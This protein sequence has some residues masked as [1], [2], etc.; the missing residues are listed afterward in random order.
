[1]R[2]FVF[3][4]LLLTPLLSWA[5]DRGELAK[6]NPVAVVALTYGETE[7]K[8]VDGDWRPLYW[9]DLIRPED[10]IRCAD[11]G[12][13]VLTFFH[14][15]HQEVLEPMT[16]VKV[17]FRNVEKLSEEG[18]VR[19]SRPLDRAVTEIPI[20]YM[21]MRGLYRKEFEKADEPGAMEREK[22]FLGSYVKA[23]AYPPVFVWSDAGVKPYKFQMFNEW[24]EFLY[25]NKSNETRFKFPYRGPFNMQKNSLYRWQVTDANDNIMVRKY[26]F[27]LLT[28][29][30]SREVAS[31]EK[32]FERAR[33]NNKLL[34]SDYADLFLLYNQ[35]KLVDKSLRLLQKMSD[36]DPE[37]PVLYRALVRAYLAKGCPAHALEAHGRELQLGGVDPIK[38]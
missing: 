24:D 14:D 27:V 18:N 11:N 21:L 33:K 37:N 10:E 29:P 1:M 16:E 9:M 30:H 8:H 3:L 23:H 28:L 6:N 17:S 36:M 25:E 19:K 13:V 31:R 20:P 32:A 12:K 35:R 22:I 15:D 2:N 34:P 38:D 7:L 26:S 4:F 5:Q